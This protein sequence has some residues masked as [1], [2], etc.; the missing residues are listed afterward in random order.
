[1]FIIRFSFLYSCAVD[2]TVEFQK[3]TGNGQHFSFRALVFTKTKVPGFYL[4]CD[5]VTCD[6]DDPACSMGCRQ[7]RSLH[8]N[9]L[10][11]ISREQSPDHKRKMKLTVHVVVG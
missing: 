6:Q 7:R 5:T 4:H 1:M 8:Q 9:Q 10:K 3:S 11:M 2:S